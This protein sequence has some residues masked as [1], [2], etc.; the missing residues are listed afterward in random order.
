[1]TGS[2]DITS[3]FSKKYFPLF[4]YCLYSIFTLYLYHETIGCR[5]VTDAMNWLQIY[6]TRGLNGIYNC[7]G[8]L[9]L[10]YFYHA[11]NLLLYAVFGLHETGWYIV[12]SLLHALVAL[13]IFKTGSRLLRSFYP[14][15]TGIALIASLLFLVN[16]YQTEVTV[17]GAAIHYLLVCC[18]MLAA[19]LSFF[20]YTETQTKKHL[21][22][23]HAFFV[24]A[25]FSH[26]MAMCFPFITLTIA[27]FLYAEDKAL[28]RLL[29]RKCL[30]VQLALLTGY[31]ALNKVF[32]GNFTGH[33]AGYTMGPL[34][35]SLFVSNF[36]KYLLKDIFLI[37]TFP[38]GVRNNFYTAA[39]NVVTVYSTL[40]IYL[41]LFIFFI[42]RYATLSHYLKL[43]GICLL[44]YIFALAPVIKLYFYNIIPIE[45]DRLNYF[46]FIFSSL[47][48]AVILHRLKLTL[49]IGIFAI[50]MFVSFHA[51]H[52]NV[53]A[54]QG[55][56]AVQQ[57]LESS[58]TWQTDKSI[59]ILNDP[60]NFNG[61]YMY[62]DTIGKTKLSQ[63]LEF[64]HGL[65]PGNIISVLQYNMIEKSDSVFVEK[66]SDTQLKVTFAQ[67]GNWWW[68]KGIG[69]HD[70]ET[71][72]VKVDIDDIGH[73]YIVTFKQ[74]QPGDIFL[75][76]CG[77][78]WRQKDDF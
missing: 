53:N 61:A 16:P 42:R 17:W 32:L 47:L 52:R 62:R 9:S 55:S 77:E 20:R 48:L 64:K 8:D 44:L 30:L 22:F 36:N 12:F 66:I 4:L 19:L 1:M 73:S 28:F 72:K 67:W 35:L 60:D 51:L 74:K 54:W 68:H 21:L 15:S 59:Y 70:Y 11:A 18:F 37:Q 23:C 6:D 3:F 24:L 14:Q 13:L 65:Q 50:L 39:D 31:M 29:M 10:Q 45:A 57:A 25:L 75:Y 76:Q 26:G 43:T 7:Y 69:A 33:A 2:R 5:L 41:T 71:A 56:A 49:R 38:S 78:Y 27:Y 34:S 58:F 63:A 40:L 46:S